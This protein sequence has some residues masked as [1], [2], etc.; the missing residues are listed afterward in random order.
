M[1][2]GKE[3]KCSKG[4]QME[5]DDEASATGGP[6]GAGGYMYKCVYIYIYI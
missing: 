4:K 6:R 2:G 3:V 1:E 5:E